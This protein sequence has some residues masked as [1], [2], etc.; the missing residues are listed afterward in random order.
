MIG[1]TLPLSAM[2]KSPKS[3]NTPHRCR[4]PAPLRR[5][6]ST[7]EGFIDVEWPPGERAKYEE[8]V[9]GKPQITRLTVIP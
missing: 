4:F 1:R 3:R 6:I 8:E 7:E 5:S 2:P 9:L